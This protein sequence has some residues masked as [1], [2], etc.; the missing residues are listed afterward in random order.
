MVKMLA[1]VATAACVLL[2]GAA[3]AKAET[4]SATVSSKGV[5]AAVQSTTLA[6]AVGKLSRLLPARFQPSKSLKLVVGAV[7][8][9]CPLVAKLAVKVHQAYVRRSAPPI[10]STVYSPYTSLMATRTMDL[11][12]GAAYAFVSWAGLGVARYQEQTSVGS[13]WDNPIAVGGLSPSAWRQVEPG[14]TYR[15]FVRGLDAGNRVL[16]SWARSARFRLGVVDTRVN[17]NGWTTVSPR[18]AY[19]GTITYNT[20]RSPGD[21]TYTVKGFAM[22]VVGP[23]SPRGGQADLY[24]DGKFARRIS[25]Y[26]R[27]PQA[28]R[29]V[30]SWSWY[31]DGPHHV[32]LRPLNG[33][34]DLDAMLVLSFA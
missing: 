10:Q 6:A 17:H 16:T 21:L 15:F 24:V 5:C 29:L 8:A 32:V 31:S 20:G 33:E 18:N 12:S 9:S 7:V 4:R 28:G 3:S 1:A 22:A 30:F 34:I 11:R 14:A 26:S 23:V 25:L 19:G 27:A 13:G 2:C